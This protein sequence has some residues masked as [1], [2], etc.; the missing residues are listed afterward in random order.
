[1]FKKGQRVEMTVV[2]LEKIRMRHG[3]IRKHRGTGVKMASTGVVVTNSRKAGQVSVRLDS[4]HETCEAEYFP[5]EY[6][7]AETALDAICY[8][9]EE[10]PA[11][12]HRMLA[13]GPR[14]GQRVG[15]CSECLEDL[16][17][18]ALV[19]SEPEQTATLQS[20]GQ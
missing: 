5:V 11:E 17:T 9:C 13:R 14:E 12:T 6:W 8:A 18:R 2:G 3:H 4:M 1:M 15:L 10:K 16:E 20:G 7:Q 19:V